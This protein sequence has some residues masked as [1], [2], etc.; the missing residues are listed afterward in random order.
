MDV[1]S[2]VTFHLLFINFFLPTNSFFSL[3]K[4]FFLSPPP[5]PVTLIH[6]LFLS[7]VFPPSCSN[8]FDNVPCL[9]PALSHWH[10]QRCSLDFQIF[11][12]G[13]FSFLS[14]PPPTVHP[15]HPLSTPLLS[16]A[17]SFPRRGRRPRHVATS[18]NSEK[19]SSWR[20]TSR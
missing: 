14:V 16:F 6:F 4:L 8:I 19:S 15:P 20:R 7:Q 17:E 3:A 12:P 11:F 9:I 2:N 5:P 18:R 10:W 1:T 13:P